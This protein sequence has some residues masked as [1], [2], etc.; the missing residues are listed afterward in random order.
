MVAPEN[1]AVSVGTP[2]VLQAILL[3]GLLGYP[4]KINPDWS[5]VVSSIA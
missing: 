3:S 1:L 4:I 2:I 5:G